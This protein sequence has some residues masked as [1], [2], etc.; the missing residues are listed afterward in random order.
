MTEKKSETVDVK[1]GAG[2]TVA[3]VETGAERDLSLVEKLLAVKRSVGGVSKGDRNAQQGFNFRGIDAVM[4]AVAGPFIKHGIM[5]Y[6]AHIRSVKRGTAST[7]KGSVMNTVEVIVQYAFTDGHD[8]LFFEAPGEAFDS[9]DKATAK[10]MSVAYRTALLQALTL[11]TDEPDPDSETYD[12]QPQ[13]VEQI[14]DEQLLKKIE[15]STTLDE[16]RGL[17]TDQKISS[18]SAAVQK[19]ASEK[20][21]RL[22]GKDGEA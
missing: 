17:W 12:A 10:A 3:V 14:T 15:A 5:A 6:P 9:G 13:P 4:N 19:K 18:R 7:A 22:Q 1:D 16:M 20:V 8:T 11:P 21:S 2:E